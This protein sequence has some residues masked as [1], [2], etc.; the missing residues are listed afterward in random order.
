ML[1]QY[2]KLFLKIN[3]KIKKIER[4][5]REI[6]CPNARDP[7]FENDDEKT[8]EIRVVNA[9][10]TAAQAT[11]VSFRV[12]TTDSYALKS[13]ESE[14]LLLGSVLLNKLEHSLSL[15]T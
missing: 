15:H 8:E 4:H 11:P 1:S 7:M 14:L 12:M 3:K 13:C 5:I 9:L 2:N 6:K 10:E